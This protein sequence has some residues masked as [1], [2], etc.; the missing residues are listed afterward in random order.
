MVTPTTKGESPILRPI[1]SDETKS[2]SAPLTINI[3]ETIKIV[4]QSNII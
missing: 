4:I 2:Q 1:F 3:R